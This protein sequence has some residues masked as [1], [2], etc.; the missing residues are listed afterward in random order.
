MEDRVAFED[1]HWG[2]SIPD[3]RTTEYL[4]DEMGE[5]GKNLKSAKECNLEK[6]SL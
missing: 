1:L 6:P 5:M 4:N 3:S 2:V